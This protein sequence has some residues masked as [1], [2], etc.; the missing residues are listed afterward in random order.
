MICLLICFS[1][2]VKN[3]FGAATES[4]IDIHSKVSLKNLRK[5]PYTNDVTSFLRFFE[6]YLFRE[7][8]NRLKNLS[9]FKGLPELAKISGVHCRYRLFYYICLLWARAKNLRTPQYQIIYCCD[10]QVHKFD[11]QLFESF[12]KV[13][14]L[15]GYRRI[16]AKLNLLFKINEYILLSYTQYLH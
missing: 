11:W 12:F 9:N 6:N 7:P 15:Y 3:Y 1:L 4:M 10:G 14:F 16:R 5:G 13:F 2:I 8:V